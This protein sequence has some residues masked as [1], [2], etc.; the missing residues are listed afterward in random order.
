MAN[1]Q[2]SYAKKAHADSFLKVINSEVPETKNN[3]ALSAGISLRD[4]VIGGV[5]GGAIGYAIGKPFPTLAAGFLATGLGHFSGSKALQLIGIG[6]MSATMVKASS[7]LKG[8]QDMEGLDGVKDRLSAFKDAWMEKLMLDK[9][10]KKKDATTLTGTT[11]G[12]GDVQFFDYPDTVNGDLAALNE[13]ENQLADSA[14]E[15]QGTDEF[16]GTIGAADYEMGLLD[17]DNPMY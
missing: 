10:F 17:M 13:I 16:Q 11:N 1:K 6:M 15:F 4:M 9:V 3:A 2:N 14:T 12:I 7:S 5:A 8:T